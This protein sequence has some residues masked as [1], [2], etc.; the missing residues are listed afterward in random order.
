[1]FDSERAMSDIGNTMS[2]QTRS[3]AQI[4]PVNTLYD[5]NR[6]VS[7]EYCDHCSACTH[8]RGSAVLSVSE[9][10]VDSASIY[11]IID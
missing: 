6:S 10:S 7:S 3:Y 5:V 9:E 2:I 4:M 11:H 1:M 8:E